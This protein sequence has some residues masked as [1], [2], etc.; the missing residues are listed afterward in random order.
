MIKVQ[1]K[2]ANAIFH[3]TVLIEFF[4]LIVNFLLCAGWDHV[5]PAAFGCYP[6]GQA[7]LNLLKN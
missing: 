3:E 6:N 7:I 2:I 5:M 4:A 1:Q